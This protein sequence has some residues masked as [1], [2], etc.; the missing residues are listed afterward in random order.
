EIAFE[1]READGSGIRA[2]AGFDLRGTD[3]KK[4]IQLITGTSL[5]AA[6]APYLSV[7]IRESSFVL[8]FV[9]RSAAN[10]RCAIDERQ[11]V[12]FLK[13]DHQAVRQFEP[14]RLLRFEDRQLRNGNLLPALS[15][16]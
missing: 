12:I 1:A 16:R 5:R 2:A 13:E 3:F 15:L 10:S 4:V 14:F 7:N 8:R 9:H 11:F 6:R